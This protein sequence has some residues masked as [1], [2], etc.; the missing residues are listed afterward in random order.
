ML[1]FAGSWSGKLLDAG[2]YDQNK[3]AAEC[4]ATTTTTVFALEATGKVFKLD[5]A[6][7]S[8]AAAALKNRADRSADPSK[9][10]SKEVTA[11]VKGEENGGV[12]AVESIEVQ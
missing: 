1:S 12:I 5:D 4:S 6:G 10:Q 3:K 11:Q 8:K 9:P 2:C 7:N